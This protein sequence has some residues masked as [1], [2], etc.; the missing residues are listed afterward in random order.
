MPF[1]ITLAIIINNVTI[2]DGIKDCNPEKSFPSIA[3]L[4]GRLAV[5]RIHSKD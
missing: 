4:A 1:G 2:V 3:T 5:S